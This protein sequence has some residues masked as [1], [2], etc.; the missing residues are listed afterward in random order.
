MCLIYG[1]RL[2]ICQHLE[3]IYNLVQFIVVKLLC[4]WGNILHRYMVKIVLTMS[5]LWVIYMN[6]PLIPLR[7]WGKMEEKKYEELLISQLKIKQ[8]MATGL[9]T[10][11]KNDLNLT[12]LNLGLCLKPSS[13]R[14]CS[15]Y[16]SPATLNFK[17]DWKKQFGILYKW[18]SF[19]RNCILWSRCLFKSYLIV[20][21]TE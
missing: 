18:H 12:V 19:T 8:V 2:E 1:Q 14:N 15:S 7:Q 4:F 5:G 17:V 13:D 3:V 9:I 21:F 6:V 11:N 16:I 20:L 10:L